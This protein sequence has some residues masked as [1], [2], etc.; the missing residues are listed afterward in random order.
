[1][2]F[3]SCGWVDCEFGHVE[4][5]SY[6]AGDGYVFVISPCTWPGCWVGSFWVTF[7]AH[8][9]VARSPVDLDGQDKAFRG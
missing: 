3:G 5:K 4:N 1:M 7:S 9:P 2:G 8:E 6:S